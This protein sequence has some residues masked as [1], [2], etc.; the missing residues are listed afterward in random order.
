MPTEELRKYWRMASVKTELRRRIKWYQSWMQQD[1]GMVALLFSNAKGDEVRGFCRNDG[2]GGL[3]AHPTPWA[4]Q[5]YADLDEWAREGRTSEHYGKRWTGSTP[6][7]LEKEM[8][9]SADWTRQ[10][11]ARQSS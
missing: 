3:G 11:C 7:F 5:F 1:T 9:T 2:E 6:D 8:K 4:T 10:S